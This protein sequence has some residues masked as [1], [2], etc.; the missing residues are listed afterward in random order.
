MSIG[1]PMEPDRAEGQVNEARAATF[2]KAAWGF[3]AYNA[4]VIVWGAYVRASGSGA[5]CG[6]HWPTC[7]GDV[8]PRPK[9]IA[10]MVE[11]SHRFTSGIALVGTIVLAIWAFRVFPKG[12]RVRTASVVSFA[13][14]MGEALIGAGLVLFELVA[15]DKS[16]KRGLSMSLHLVNTFFLLASLVLMAHF[17]SGGRALRFKNQGFARWPL[18]GALTGMLFVGTSGG[19]AAL[20]DT[21]FPATSVG[22][23]IAQDF[24]ASAHIFLRLRMFHPVF[25][26]C[27]GLLILGAATVSRTLRPGDPKVLRMSQIVS[28]LFF[29]QLL[30]GVTNMGLLAPIPVQL[31]HL[32]VADSLWVSLV[33]LT[34]HTL[35][36][37]QDTKPLTIDA[38]STTTAALATEPAAPH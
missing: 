10:T 13:F 17:A 35:A 8:I 31:L 30:V 29:T 4:L 23:A 3:L 7:N 11:A 1:T 27:C 16:A 22:Q 18:V 33:L 20:G 12:H 34:A 28:Y 21:L 2:A 38:S 24:S 9:S 15:H 14:M 19:I 36:F 32:V 6:S 37:G 26:G 25:A 5:G